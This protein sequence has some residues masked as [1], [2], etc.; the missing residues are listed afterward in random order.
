MLDLQKHFDGDYLIIDQMEL[1]IGQQNFPMDADHFFYL[2][3]EHNEETIRKKLEYK[4]GN[5]LVI[6]KGELFKIDGESIPVENKTMT[7]YYRKGSE[8]EKINTF[9]PVFPDLDELK[10]EVQI[11]MDEFSDKSNEEKVKEITAYLSEILWQALRKKIYSFG[12]RKTLTFS[13]HLNH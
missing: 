2:S 4:E 1:E 9:H 13:S 11:I 7:L 12:Y 5:K 3:Y 10:D 8:S 6:D